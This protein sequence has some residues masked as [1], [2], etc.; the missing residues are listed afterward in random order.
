MLMNK[1]YIE[2]SFQINENEIIAQ[3]CVDKNHSIFDGHFPEQPVLP[4]VCMMQ[5]VKDLV[6]KAMSKKI[7]MLEVIYCKF[8]NM[9]D[10]SK[11]NIVDIFISIKENE[12]LLHVTAQLK[13]SEMVLLK[14]DAIYQ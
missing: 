11:N 3:V 1:L 10:P 8:L 2:K 4:G 5:L 13:S 12:S 9:L 7:T 6:E 14:M